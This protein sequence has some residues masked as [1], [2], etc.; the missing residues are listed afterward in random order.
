MSDKRIIKVNP[1][2]FK[3]P[4]TTKK[5]REPKQPK[6]IKIKSSSRRNN[7]NNTVKKKL[8]NLLRRKQDEKVKS[9]SNKDKIS[10]KAKNQE[11]LDNFEDEFKSSL[12]YL[13]NLSKN[14]QLT[15]HAPHNA[16]VKQP[17]TSYENVHLTLPKEL[18]EADITHHITPMFEPSPQPISTTS[19]QSNPTILPLVKQEPPKYGCLKNGSLPTYRTWHRNQTQRVYPVL[20]N[21]SSIVKPPSQAETSVIPSKKPCKRRKIVRRNFTIGKFHNKPKVGILVSNRTLRRDVTTKQK[22]IQQTQLDD[23]KKDLVKKGFIKIGCTAPPNVLRKM[24]ECVSLMCGDIKNHNPDNLMYNYL[25]GE[26]TY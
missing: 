14:T 16:T 23:I 4:D 18:Q 5:K 17:S 12:E 11:I 22:L 9:H 6:E 10:T 2:L 25:H 26:N 13:N 19:T 1:E 15:H 7:N 21:P 3:I 8:L 20:N 24:Y